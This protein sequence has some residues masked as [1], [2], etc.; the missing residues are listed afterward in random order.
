YAI[1]DELLRPYFPQ[2]KVLSGLFEVVHRLYGLTIQP[3]NDVDV[4]HKDVQFYDIIDSNN[5]LRGGFYLDLYARAH[6]RGGAWMD[7]CQVRRQT[8][9]G[10]LQTPVAYLTCNFNG[11]VGDKP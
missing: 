8:R 2:H 1:S 3:R 11:P 7:E 10:Q 4:W 9:D 6:K 5:Q